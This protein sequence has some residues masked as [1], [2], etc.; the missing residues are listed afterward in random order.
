MPTYIF[1]LLFL[2]IPE[3]IGVSMLDLSAQGSLLALLFL[4]T[5]AAPSLLIYYLYRMGFFKN[6]VLDN[7]K[8]RR[9]PYWLTI[10]IYAA[11]T[12]LFGWQLQPISQLIPGIAIILGSITISILIVALIS[13]Q[14]KIS[15]H[16]T[17]IGGLTG[18]LACLMINFDETSLFFPLLLSIAITGTLLSARL[19]LNAHTPAQVAAGVLLGL[20]TSASSILYFF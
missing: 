7:L 18:A 20:T 8:D 3:L 11:T 17:G 15:A 9:L 12:Y 6:L 5:F 4:S 14:W 1:G 19:Q 13:I 10:M 16:A 2:F